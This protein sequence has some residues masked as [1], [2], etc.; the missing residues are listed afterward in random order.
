MSTLEIILRG[1]LVAAFL[2]SLFMMGRANSRMMAKRDESRS[3]FSP[4]FI[5]DALKMKEA[6]IFFLWVFCVIVLGGVITLIS[7]RGK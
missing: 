5:V 2:L 1:L 7:Y 3:F 6:Y 4:M